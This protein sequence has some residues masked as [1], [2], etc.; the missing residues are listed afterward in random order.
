MKEEFERIFLLS[1]SHS[2]FVNKILNVYDLD[3]YF[4]DIFTLDS[5]FNSKDDALK[6]ISKTERVS[7]DEI[8]YIG[9][10]EEDVKLAKR[11]GCK[12][13]IIKSEI[14]WE[15]QNKLGIKSL[16]PDAVIDKL[17]DLSAVLK[18]L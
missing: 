7:I 10:T 18:S 8:V 16:G 4:D 13:V 2:M 1:N 5:G 15:G 3:R 11:V 12:V 9:D 6:H 14:S 17:S